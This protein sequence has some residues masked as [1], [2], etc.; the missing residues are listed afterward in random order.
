MGCSKRHP[1]HNQLQGYM[2]GSTTSIVWCQA[3]AAAS[4]ISTQRQQP[5]LTFLAL[6]ERCTAV[7]TRVH[8]SFKACATARSAAEGCWTDM[9]ATAMRFAAKKAMQW[10]EA[11]YDLQQQQQQEEYRRDWTP[12][13]IHYLCTCVFVCFL[14]WMA[15]WALSLAIP[16]AECLTGV[17]DENPTPSTNQQTAPLPHLTHSIILLLS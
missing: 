15:C 6:P 5:L 7:S 17:A 4:A 13:P 16:L 3:S 11:E 14:C 8:T 2:C 12:S 9:A 10:G 1:L